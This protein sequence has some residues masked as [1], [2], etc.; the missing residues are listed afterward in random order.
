MAPPAQQINHL[1]IDHLDLL[2][3]AVLHNF[4]VGAKHKYKPPL[5]YTKYVEIIADACFEIKY[6]ELGMLYP[7][8]NILAALR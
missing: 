2:I 7:W 8:N 4:V 1:K 6:F 3:S 5:P